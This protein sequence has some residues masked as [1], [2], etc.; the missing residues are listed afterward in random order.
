MFEKVLYP[1]D[2]SDCSK[3]ALN[4]VVKLKDAG[5]KEVVVLHVIDEKEI[6]VMALG[7]VW[8]GEGVSE[9]QDQIL[10]KVE[11]DAK[12]KLEEVKSQLEEMGIKADVRAVVGVPFKKIVEIADE[13][14]V[15][16][17]V[18]GS[19]GKSNVEGI[20]LGSVSENVVRMTN[21]PVLIVR[22]D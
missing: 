16:L 12:S 6:D 1:T 9:Y 21:K 4:Y 15:S 2:F 20:L 11:A 18:L 13:E 22:R 5:T 17:I 14:R 8:V 10:K 3:K 7:A 19:H